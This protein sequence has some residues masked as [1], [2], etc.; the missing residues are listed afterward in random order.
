VCSSRKL[1][2]RCFL[3]FGC[4]CTRKIQI[5]SFRELYRRSSCY[6]E[7]R[8]LSLLLNV[9]YRVKL[10]T[11]SYHVIRY[12]GSRQWKV[13]ERRFP[14]LAW[15][16][17]HCVCAF[18]D[19]RPFHLLHVF[20]DSELCMPPQN[21]HFLVSSMPQVSESIAHASLSLPANFAQSVM[22]IL[23]CEFRLLLFRR[24]TQTQLLFIPQF[25][26]SWRHSDEIVSFVGSKGDRYE[27]DVI[28]FM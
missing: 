24:Q 8:F 3:T 11:V 7:S 14:Y 19:I 17:T 6:L 27:L 5:K 21:A 22:F 18:V 28:T 10:S 9:A 2:C 13:S 23:C 20:F 16:W 26:H 1:L 4:K 15:V 25:S 12:G